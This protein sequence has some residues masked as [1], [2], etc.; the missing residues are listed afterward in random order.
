MAVV[1]LGDD[2]SNGSDENSLTQ[3]NPLVGPP[4]KPKISQAQMKPIRKRTRTQRR[5]KRIGKWRNKRKEN[6]IGPDNE[7]ESTFT[8]NQ[9]REK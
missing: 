9:N 1:F 7:K 2:R 4:L 3:P 5:I 8:G 6:L